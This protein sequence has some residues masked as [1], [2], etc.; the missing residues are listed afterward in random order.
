[1]RFFGLVAFERVVLEGFQR[2]LSSPASYEG[3]GRRPSF[4]GAL[5]RA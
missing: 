4:C 2:R 3:K 5:S 1:M